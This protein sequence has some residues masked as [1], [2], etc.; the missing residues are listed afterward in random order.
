MNK[1]DKLGSEC[2]MLTSKINAGEARLKS[3][4][5]DYNERRKAYTAELR[6]K[7]TPV[8]AALK[9]GETVNGQTTIEGWCR[10]ANPDAK[11]PERQFQKIM[12]MGEV[13]SPRSKVGKRH[14]VKPGDTLVI[15]GVKIPIDRIKFE[16]INRDAERLYRVVI[17]SENR[18]PEAESFELRTDDQPIKGKK[19]APVKK[20]GQRETRVA[21]H[22]A[23]DVFDLMDVP[24]GGAQKIKDQFEAAVAA[25]PEW[26]SVPVAKWRKQLEVQVAEDKLGRTGMDDAALKKKEKRY[27]QRVNPDFIL[28][29]AKPHKTHKLRSDGRTWCGKT[30]GDT[31][32]KDARMSDDPT[33]R[34]CHVGMEHDAALKLVH[35]NRPGALGKWGETFCGLKGGD[36]RSAARDSGEVTCPNCLVAV[37]LYEAQ[38]PAAKALATELETRKPS[39]KNGHDKVYVARKYADCVVY[40]LYQWC[41]TL[42]G[43]VEDYNVVQ[44]TKD[45]NAAKDW[46]RPARK[47]DRGISLPTGKDRPKQHPAAK[48]LAAAVDGAEPLTWAQKV[49]IPGSPEREQLTKENI[50]LL[51]HPAIDPNADDEFAGEGD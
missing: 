25:H 6:E 12:S 11:Y 7:L 2:M 41:G 27:S 24:M 43:G 15:N 47:G 30:L 36:V 1:L 17:L 14:N 49:C 5:K 22:N 29:P 45:E 44:E 34:Q 38:H 31:L 19:T 35:A 10:L 23:T 4:R 42:P 39:Q 16:A 3:E 46:G 8:W 32:A 21:L 9:A 48:A 37:K 33:C 20:L 40:E 18:M 26:H 50:Y 28:M 51:E 13:S